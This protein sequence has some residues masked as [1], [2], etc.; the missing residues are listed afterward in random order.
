M[1]QILT[2]HII[3]SVPRAV[4]L[5]LSIGISD[6]IEYYTEPRVHKYHNCP[7]IMRMSWDKYNCF[8]AGLS[9]I[10]VSWHMILTAY[11]LIP[12]TKETTDTLSLI[13]ISI[14]IVIKLFNS[15]KD[16]YYLGHQL[17]YLINTMFLTYSTL[18]IAKQRF[19]N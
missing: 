6:A 7:D 9:G 8:Y 13:N 10:K 18:L 11:L 14:P 19:L 2:N 12:F 4:Q 15:S 5:I 17:L 1:M 16:N 3:Q